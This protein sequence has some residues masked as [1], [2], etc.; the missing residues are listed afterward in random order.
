MLTR[1][2]GQEAE[3]RKML[4]LADKAGRGV[5]NMLTRADKGGEGGLDRHIFN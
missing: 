4:I 2:T 5:W 1:L 3:V